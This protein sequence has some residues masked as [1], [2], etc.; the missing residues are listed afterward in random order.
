MD[1][2]PRANVNLRST[3]GDRVQ[4]A[5]NVPELVHVSAQLQRV[6]LRQEGWLVL[7]LQSAAILRGNILKLLRDLHSD[8]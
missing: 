7:G 8:K 1:Q 5:L 2:A 4:L 3:E 6:L